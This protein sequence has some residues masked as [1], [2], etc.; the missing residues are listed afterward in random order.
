MDE[1]GP[2]PD[3]ARPLIIER[4]ELQSRP[5]R[6]VSAGMTAVF[7]AMWAYLWL[8]AVALL[9]WALGFERFYEEMVRREGLGRVLE[10]LGWYAAVIALLAGSLVLWATYNYLRFRGVERRQSQRPVGLDGLAAFARI[11]PAR[12]LLWQQA[13][14][15]TVTHDDD[16]AIAGVEPFP[17]SPAREDAVAPRQPQLPA[18]AAD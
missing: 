3:A 4:P 6:V 12:L 11:E 16:G 10:L 1:S 5:Q 14:V 7:W 17:G 15:M 8:P 13:R 9:G 2:R 18:R